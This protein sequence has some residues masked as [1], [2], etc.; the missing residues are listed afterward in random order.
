MITSHPQFA[1]ATVNMF[2]A[3]MMGVGI[4][5]PVF[6]FDLLRQDPNNPPPAGWSIQPSHPELLD[7]LAKDFEENGYDL[8]RLVRM[9][10]TSSA[11]QLS[12]KFPGEWQASYAKYYA[13]KFVRRLTSEEMYNAIVASTNLY[14]E[15]PIRG[16]DLT[17]R[18]ATE[19]RSPEDMGRFREAAFFLKV[20]GQA[21]RDYS[22][23]N[24]QG[25]ID[26]A[27]MLM[28]S[29]F[30]TE[31]LEAKPGSSLAELIAQQPPLGDEQLIEELYYRFLSRPPAEGETAK[32]RELIA[33]NRTQGLE[34]L[35]WLLMN[36]L[37]FIF[38]Y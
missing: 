5:D 30:V 36:K 12:S 6:D 19:T 15:I 9:I 23:R 27:I 21:N 38:N 11:Y 35:Q 20:F 32:A 7:A 16:T 24:N 14:E 33:E 25:A 4:V 31:R 13:R 22:E 17:V 34:D 2:W 10:A 26:Q 8:R 3:E 28:N 37:E 1:R 18:Y 29:S